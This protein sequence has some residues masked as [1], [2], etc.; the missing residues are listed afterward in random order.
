VGVADNFFDLGGH[1][2]LAMRLT[3]AMEARFGRRLPLASLFAAPTV[4]ELARVLAVPQAAMPRTG[5]AGLR[6][7]GNGAPWFHIPGI[8]G[9]EFLPLAVAARTGTM[10]RFYDGLE[11]PG[12][13]GLSA[14]LTR[15]EDIAAHLIR[16]M[17]QV[18][19]AGPYCLSGYS[20]GGVVA[21]EM[22]RQLAARGTAVEAVL[23]WD[24]FAPAAFRK[25]SAI[26]TLRVLCHHLAGL[27]HR[28]RARF[29]GPAGAQEGQV[30]QRPRSAE[31]SLA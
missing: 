12:L 20:F 17:E 22:A 3:R 14:P 7:Q 27:G 21:Y 13:D 2:L 5:T 6:G 10:R 8:A 31:T 15:V 28:E 24:S 4:E 9:F 30:P 18:A 1:S 23:L 29:L 16:Q 11:Y 26:E 19:P 25:R